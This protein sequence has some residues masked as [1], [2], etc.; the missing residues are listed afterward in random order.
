MINSL[1]A[2]LLAA[3]AVL[4]LAFI[5]LTGLALQTAVRERA[6]QAEHDRLQGLSYALLG[7][8]DITDDGSFK[9]APRVLPESDLSR[10]DSGLYAMVID[11]DGKVIW[12]SPSLLGTIQMPSVPAVGQWQELRVAGPNDADLLT[13]SFGFR[14]VTDNGNDFRYTLIV[15]ENATTFVKQMTRFRGVLW[16][17]LSASALIL[18]V[19]ELLILRWGLAPLRRLARNLASLESDGDRRLE[20]DYP[21]EI[22]PLVSNLNTMLANDQARLTRYRNALGDLAHSL[23]TPMAILRGLAEDDTL[24]GKQR[25]PLRAQLARM[26]DI[27]DYQLQKAAAAG[28]RTLARPLPIAPPAERLARA[29]TK[30][31][32]GN[33]TRFDIRIDDHLRAP[34]DAGDLT[35]MLGTLMD[36]AAKYGKNLVIVDARREDGDLVLWVDDNG[37]G[38]A[39]SAPQRLL[40]RGV[41]ADSTREGQG[42]GLAVAAEIVRSYNGKIELSA[43]PDGGA[44]VIVRIP[45]S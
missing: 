29:L 32:A 41:R 31:Y 13:L 2:R 10:P 16:T 38:F 8:A 5:V 43:T 30:V 15:A 42:L 27:L 14:W 24:P 17:L 6:E 33:G 35:E 9:L 28:K 19:V 21:D 12:H 7:S 37:P 25:G 26:N 18:L 3:T 45:E 40:E 22:Q 39:D 4:L 11:D 1:R 20:G 34:I 36:N 44:R 23:K